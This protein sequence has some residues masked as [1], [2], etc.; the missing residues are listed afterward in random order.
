MGTFR[1]ITSSACTYVFMC[2]MHIHKMIHMHLSTIQNVCL[3]SV[4]PDYF[5]AFAAEINYVM[6]HQWRNQGRA[7]TGMCLP[8]FGP[9][10]T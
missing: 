8:N 3:V 2:V 10:S 7:R 6:D 4:V 5:F 1:F 9:Y